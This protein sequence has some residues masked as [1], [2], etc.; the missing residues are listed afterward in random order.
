MA[1]KFS[2]RHWIDGEW[3]DSGQA[4]QSINPVNREVIGTYTEAGEAEA[5]P[6]SPRHS[7]SS[8]RPTGA[9]IGDSGAGCSTSPVSNDPALSRPMLGSSPSAESIFLLARFSCG[10]HVDTRTVIYV[11][12]GIAV[13]TC[14]WR[15]ERDSNP[16]RAFDPYTLSRG[17]PSTTRPSLRCEGKCFSLWRGCRAV[18]GHHTQSR[19][20]AAKSRW[21]QGVYVVSRART[22]SCTDS[23][24][25]SSASGLVPPACAK[26]A[27]PPPR[28]PTSAATAPASSPA[29]MREV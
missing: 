26:S 24:A 20:R 2:A 22:N 13:S 18:G 27:R 6:P 23:S 14:F 17:A 21:A 15:R 9:R 19:A 1:A 25:A 28:P 7:R 4:A 10:F 12:Y 11:D 8:G 29:W 16:R 5:K 3:V